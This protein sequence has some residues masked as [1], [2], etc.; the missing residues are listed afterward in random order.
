MSGCPD[1]RSQPPIADAGSY[2][3]DRGEGERAI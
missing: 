2:A 1:R 3:P